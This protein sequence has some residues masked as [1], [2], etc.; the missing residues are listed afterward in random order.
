MTLGRNENMHVRWLYH[1]FWRA[2]WTMSAFSF[3][4]AYNRFRRLF[5][6]SSSFNRAI[7]EV[8]IP[9]NLA[10]HLHT[11]AGLGL[12]EDGHNLTV[13]KLRTF[14]AES[15]IYLDCEKIPLL[16][17]IKYW[18]DYPSGLNCYA[19]DNRLQES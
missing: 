6:V 12:L 9:P 14:H 1:F 8:S 11:V 18:D 2:S 10:R 19:L 3:T 5:S 16:T 13:G 17:S 15:P 4:S 7:S